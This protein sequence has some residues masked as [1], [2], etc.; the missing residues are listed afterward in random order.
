MPLPIKGVNLIFLIIIK[1]LLGE[2]LVV[3]IDLNLDWGVM[4]H[5]HSFFVV[6]GSAH[7]LIISKVPNKMVVGLCVVMEKV[8][9]QAVL[10]DPA[11]GDRRIHKVLVEHGVVIDAAY[12][13]DL[14]L[15][16]LNLSLGPGDSAK[17]SDTEEAIVAVATS[18]LLPVRILL[19]L[20]DLD[21]LVRV[22][23]DLLLEGELL[24]LHAIHLDI[25]LP[26]IS[27]GHRD[28]SGRVLGDRHRLNRVHRGHV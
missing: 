14:D 10:R 13:V 26:V 12:L 9:E 17:D 15:R 28:C 20:L 6:L 2:I 8:H 23:S 11:A 25:G 7:H 21:I 22:S 5:L 27:L 24:G 1:T 4:V 18:K 3:A 19:D 16:L